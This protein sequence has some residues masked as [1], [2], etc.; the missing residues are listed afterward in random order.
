MAGGPTGAI[1]TFC[2]EVS[3]LQNGEL[4]I[5]A[6]A[7]TI[8]GGVLPHNTVMQLPTPVTGVPPVITQLTVLLAVAQ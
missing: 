4:G 5:C 3:E 7:C 8:N 1:C 6:N 2:K